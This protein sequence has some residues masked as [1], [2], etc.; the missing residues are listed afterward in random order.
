MKKM[1]FAYTWVNK[2]ICCVR[3]VRYVVR[4]NFMLL[5]VIVPERGLRQGDPY[6]LIFFFNMEVISRMLLHD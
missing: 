6:L 2:F 4:C 3:L 5:E 1:G